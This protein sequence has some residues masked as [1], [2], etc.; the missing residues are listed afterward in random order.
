MKRLFLI[1]FVAALSLPTTKAQELN[2]QIEVLTD[3]VQGIN[4]AIFESLRE[5]IFELMNNR[6]WTNDSYTIEERINC[7]MILNINRGASASSNTYSATLQVISG[8]PIF[9]TGYSSPVLNLLDDNVVFEFVP[10]TQ[11]N[12]NPDQF[13]SN[14]MSILAF[15]AYTIIAFDY[16]T[17][18]PRGGTPYFEMAN[19]I[20]QSAQVSSAPGW[21]AFEGDKNRYWIVSDML[22]RTFEPMRD[23]MYQYHRQGLD[24]MSDKIPQGRMAILASLEKFDQI[25]KIK[26]MAYNTQNFFL[27]KSDEIVNIFSQA[28]PPERNAVFELLSRIDPGNLSKYEK[29]QKGK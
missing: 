11:Y 18:S 22:H 21:K 26:P 10:N 23:C 25:H 14:L 27:A 6:K 19:R 7:T 2:C 29:M 15:Y 5:V 4:P 17:F 1:F 20:V 3:Q 13:Q 9:N 12:F 28:Q 24:M 16:D 8:R